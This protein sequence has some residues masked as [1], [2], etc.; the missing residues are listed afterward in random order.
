MGRALSSQFRNSFSGVFFPGGR[1]FRCKRTWPSFATIEDCK[2][3]PPVIVVVNECDPLRDEGIDFYRKCMRAGVNAQCRIVV[4]TMHG[5]EL[6]GSMPEVS[7]ETARSIAFFAFGN[8][9][10]F[11]FKL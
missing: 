2:G 10:K 8:D 1:S 9:A 6:L 7:D 4:G 11:D 3:L 5:G